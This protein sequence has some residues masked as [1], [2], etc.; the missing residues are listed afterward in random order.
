MTARHD[1]GRRLRCLDR[2]RGHPAAALHLS[3]V[4]GWKKAVEMEANY[5]VRSS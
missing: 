5:A 2:G 3:N 4:K 1:V